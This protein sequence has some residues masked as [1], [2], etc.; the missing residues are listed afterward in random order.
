MTMVIAGANGD[1][2]IGQTGKLASLDGHFMGPTWPVTVVGM[3][4]WK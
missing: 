2:A 1:C 4:L 3:V